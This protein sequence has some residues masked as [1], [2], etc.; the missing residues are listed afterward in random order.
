MMIV[1][2]ILIA[3]GGVAKKYRKNEIIFLEGDSPRYYYQ[4]ITGKV[5]L[6]NNSDTK[7]LTQGIFT[8]GD[9][10]G[11]PP[12]FIDEVYPSTAITIS[13]TVI[14]R[15]LKEN[16]LK[17]ID[18]YPDIQKNFLRIFSWRI[19]EKSRLAR[20]LINNSPEERIITFLRYY[21]KKIGTSDE[22]LR[23]DFTRQEIANFTGLCVETVIRTLSRMNA[24][25]K[26]AI[27][28]KKLYY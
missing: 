16:F 2:D 28:D 1:N 3:W 23:I 21:K 6:F 25:K 18:E 5:K 20:E 13:E 7:E 22:R 4:I 17:L 15:L 9:G 11:E 26:V 19:Y 27:I 10:F 8:D 24:K 12:L 14:I